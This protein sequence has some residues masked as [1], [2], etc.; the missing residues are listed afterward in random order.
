MP[1]YNLAVI[2]G[3]GIGPEVITEGRKVLDAVAIQS[4]GLF[5]RVTEFPWGSDYYRETGLMMPEDGLARLSDYDA[6]LFGAVGDP[7]I[8]DHVT[9]QGLL[10]PMRPRL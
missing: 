3:D 2:A 8:P 5:F 1:E 6:V 4:D 9:L 7:D 10:L